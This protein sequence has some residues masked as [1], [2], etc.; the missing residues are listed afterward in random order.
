[1]YEN[2]RKFF[3]LGFFKKKIWGLRLESSLGS[4]FCKTFC[5]R[6]L[7][8]FWMCLPVLNI[9]FP[10]YKKIPLYRGSE[11][12]RVLNM[13]LVLNTPVFWIYLPW[14]EKEFRYA[15]ALNIP[16]LKYKKVPLWQGSE[17]TF[18]EI[19]ES[20]VTPGFWIYRSWNIR[21]FHYARVLNIPFPKYDR[22]ALCRGSEY[23]FP[24][25]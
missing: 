20:S 17:Y 15:S 6:C 23:N 13:L 10:K 8:V 25:M 14:I 18:S 11:Y 16:F 7:T 21:K 22:V 5:R 4:Y 9:P 24:E 2:I 3:R 1:M 12:T 19:Q